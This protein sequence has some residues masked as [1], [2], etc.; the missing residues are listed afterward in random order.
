MKRFSSTLTK[1]KQSYIL[2]NWEYS[3]SSYQIYIIHFLPASNC[4][5]RKG[6][7]LGNREYENLL[8]NSH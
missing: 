2:E 7:I 5:I 6:K 4:P 1:K 8:F 3:I